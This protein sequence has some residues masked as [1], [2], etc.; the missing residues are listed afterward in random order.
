VTGRPKI[1]I[2]GGYGL[3]G[4]LIARHLRTAG[5]DLDLILAGRNPEAGQ[6]LALELGART[7]RL[8]LDDPAPGLAG[9]GPVE[10]IVAA[11]QD[12]GDVLVAAALR[13]G[14]GHI[15]I[16]RSVDTLTPTVMAVQGARARRPIVPLA[17]WQAGVL[18]LAALQAATVFASV[19]RIELAALY[20][21]A[22]PIGPMTIADSQEFVGRALVRQAGRWIWLQGPDHPRR[23]ER[24]GQAAFDA[25]PMSV[26]DLPALGAVTDARD[27]R[28]DLGTG[29]SLGTLAGRPASHDLY[30]DLTGRLASGEMATRRMTVS[31]PKGQAHLTALGVLIAA[32]RVLGLDGGPPPPG[33]LIFP[34]T[35]LDPAAALARLAS[36]GV[37]LEAAS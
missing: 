34:E 16:T 1:L 2:A 28:F 36:F 30:I 26:L 37:R 5:H 25:L 31:D 17:H 13:S 14:A 27:I 3:V 29:E 35:L 23:V 15:G 19:E 9:I 22:D 32:E 21:Y 6:G 20:D 11:L 7:A 10:L 18:T 33:G 8:D 24:A 12:P 4:G